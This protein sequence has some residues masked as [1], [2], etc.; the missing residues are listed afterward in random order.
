MYCEFEDTGKKFKDK[1][2]FKCSNCEL[3][4]A[5]EDPNVNIICF[6]QS[7]DILNQFRLGDDES[8]IKKE[9]L[10]TTPQQAAEFISKQASDVLTN[11]STTSQPYKPEDVLCK[12]S[13]IQ[14]RLSICRK[15]EY[16]KDDSCMLCG[17]VIVREKNYM[18][19]LANKQA[20]CPDNRWGPITN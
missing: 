18:N 6:K 11:Q 16:Y 8:S 9:Q 1:K 7:K 19:K 10:F 12:E 4:I 14:A 17:C 2:I 15:C 3:E 5:L 20:S 13:D